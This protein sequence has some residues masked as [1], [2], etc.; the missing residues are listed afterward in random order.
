[1]PRTLIL[2]FH[3]DPSRSRA[4]AA[5]AA[6]AAK[7]PQTG[8]VDMQALHP[9]GCIDMQRDGATEA[10][11]LMAA[12]RIVLQFPVQWYSTPALLKS[13]LD[14]VLTRMVYILPDSEGRALLGKPLLIAATAG[15]I[16]DAYRPGGANMFTME[17]LLAP[18][19]AT[20]HR[21]GFAW[22]PPFIVYSANKLDQDALSAA[23]AEY[24]SRLRRFQ[25][26]SRSPMPVEA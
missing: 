15:N 5:L 10:A 25:V 14:A 23:A 11:R 17:A 6:E 24:A 26:V 9:D 18:L 20:A 3:P 16:P 21:C 12:D 4:N 8:V 7:L 13:W 1:M 22:S 19:R 2:L